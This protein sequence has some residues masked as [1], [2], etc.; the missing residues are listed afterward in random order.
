MNKN[1]ISSW[2]QGHFIDSR[3]YRHWTKK[4]KDQAE[5]NEI[6]LVR[7]SPTGNAICKCSSPE[8]AIWIASRLN[9]ISVL[10]KRIQELNEFTQE[11][12]V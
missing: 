6:Y 11:N 2:R 3:Q 8:D 1:E 9:Y 5:N 10:E 12:K 4:E 7:P